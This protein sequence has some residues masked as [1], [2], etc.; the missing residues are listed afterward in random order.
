MTP[1]VPS[2]DSQRTCLQTYRA[3]VD[4][5]GGHGAAR[6]P[7]GRLQERVSGGEAKQWWYPPR[8][9][10]STRRSRTSPA[11][12]S[13]SRG[14]IARIDDLLNERVSGWTPIA[15]ALRARSRGSD[16]RRLLVAR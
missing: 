6:R 11:A 15:L 14:S 2:A 16:P 3:T 7:W 4:R 13:A 12:W 8:T 10:T 9:P 1:A 5:P